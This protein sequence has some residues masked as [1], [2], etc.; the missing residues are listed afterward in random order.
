MSDLIIPTDLDKIKALALDSVNSLHSRRAYSKALDRFL[1]WYQ[2]Q[3][4]PGLTKAIVQQYKAEV[5]EPSGLSPASINLHMSAI[6]KLASEAADNGLMEQSLANGISKVSGVPNEGTRAGNWLT[7]DQAQALINA[8]DTNELKGLR[9]RAILALML[10][11]GLRRDEVAN[12]TFEH[13]QQREGRWVIV[14]LV[15]KRKRVRSVPIDSWIK[16]AVDEWATAAGIASG[17][18]VRGVYR[19]GHKVQPDSEK[20]TA[21]AVYYAVQE[22]AHQAYEQ[23]G[24]KVFLSIAPHDLRRTFAKLARKGGS[25]MAQI[26]LV[27]GHQSIQT[28]EKYIGEQLDLTDSPSDRVGLR[29]D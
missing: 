6:R 10:G 8:P 27:L 11:A 1:T 21:Q 12:L 22:A 18:V 7:K 9:D 4:R 29:L 25:D 14:D 3:G 20:T 16:R 24:D 28:T 2:A 15:G 26:Q 23:T 17:R 5:L 19:F 13:I